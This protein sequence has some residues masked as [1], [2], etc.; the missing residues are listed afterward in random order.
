MTVAQA[1]REA[2]ARLAATSDTARLDAEL[3]MAHALG[4]TRSELLL[5]RMAEPAPAAFAALVG[6]I[7]ARAR[8]ARLPSPAPIKD[9]CKVERIRRGKISLSCALIASKVERR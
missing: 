5:R 7:A 2:A 6:T 3:L 9:T 4:V 8:P 1:L